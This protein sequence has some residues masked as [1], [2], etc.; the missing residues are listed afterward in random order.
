MAIKVTCTCGKKL[1]VKDE[2]AGR[3]VKCPAC[4]TMLKLPKAKVQEES[5]D[6]EYGLDESAEDDFDDE[7]EAVPAKSRGAKKSATRGSVS[8]KGKGK[9]SSGQNRGLLIG[10][11]AGGG[12]L[13]VALLTWMFWPAG[14]A[15]KVAVDPQNNASGNPASTSGDTANSTNSAP[16]VE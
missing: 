10:L 12:V 7:H 14:P 3:Q 9:K 5:L 13:V 6:D 16:Q 2:F 4:Q 15:G 1:T 11:S 8:R